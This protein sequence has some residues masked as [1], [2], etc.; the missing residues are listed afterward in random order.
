MLGAADGVGAGAAGGGWGARGTSGDDG[1]GGQGLLLQS[2]E[3]S[4]WKRS[5]AD[6]WKKKERERGSHSLSQWML[7]GG[8]CLLIPVTGC[9]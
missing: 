3:R 2:A 6:L 9:C 4:R 8:V 5:C 7:P 1:G